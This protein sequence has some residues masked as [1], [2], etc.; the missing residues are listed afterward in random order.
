MSNE[1]V[2]IVSRSEE[3]KHKDEPKRIRAYK[4]GEIMHAKSQAINDESL[5]TH[6]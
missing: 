6:S 4:Q 5:P 1:I 3:R 2:A